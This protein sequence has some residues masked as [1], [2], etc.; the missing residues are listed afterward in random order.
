[1]VTAGLFLVVIIFSAAGYMFTSK[2][3]SFLD[4]GGITFEEEKDE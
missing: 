2:I 3:G 1:M 4:K